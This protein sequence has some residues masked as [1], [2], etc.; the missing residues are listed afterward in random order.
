MLEIGYLPNALAFGL[1]ARGL[2]LI[3][4]ISFISIACQ[5]RGLVG[6]RG[7]T[8]LRATFRS[9]AH[10]FPSLSSRML[11]FFSL[12]WLC[13]TSDFALIAIPFF[14]ACCGLCAFCGVCTQLARVGCWVAMR[15]L[16]LPVGLLYPW[17]SLLL[18]LG[19]L[20]T[21]LPAAPPLWKA[22][23][24]GGM[25]GRAS[26]L[27]PVHPWLACAVRWLL[28]R[29]MLGFG[30]KKFVGTSLRH[31]CYIK[32]F[33]VAQP[34]PT[35][36]GWL[37]CR[38]PLPLFQFAL[39]VMFVVEC[40]APLFLLP[41]GGVRAFAALSIIMLML[42]IHIGG[43]FG[44]F[45]LLTVSMSLAC[46]DVTSS[47]FDPLPA[48]DKF[49]LTRRLALASYALLSVLFLPFDSW[50]TNAFSY[51]PQ[52]A[53]ARRPVIAALLRL[54]RFASD[55][56]L[57]HAYGV[58]PPHS[59]PPIRMVTLV[60]G[61][62]DGVLW[63]RYHWRHLPCSPTSRPSFVA[64]HHPR[65]DHSLF[66][67][68]FGTSPDN[69]L[70]P[71]NSARPYAFG[72]SSSTLHRLA[73]ALLSDGAPH[74]RR[75]FRVDPFPPGTPPP[76][77]VR[78]RLMSYEPTTL[79]HAMRTG[80]FWIEECI[81]VHLPPMTLQT[82]PT[83]SSMSRAP[84]SSHADG[85]TVIAKT[86]PARGARG[87]QATA[88][89]RRSG[90]SPARHEEPP[91]AAGE[92]ARAA[93]LPRGAFSDATIAQ[94]APL[95]PPAPGSRDPLL[96]HPDLMPIWRT[97]VPKLRR[98][99]AADLEGAGESEGEVSHHACANRPSPR[100]D[101]SSSGWSAA[102]RL[103]SL[104][105]LD[106]AFGSMADADALA[107]AFW[108]AFVPFV[109]AECSMSSWAD[110]DGGLPAR[111]ARVR[112]LFTPL[113]L[114]V[115]ELILGGLT[116]RIMP[117]LEHMHMRAALPRLGGAAP[118]YFHLVLL[119]HAIVLL[120]PL[121]VQAFL[122]APIPND[123]EDAS[124]ST[125]IPAATLAA[126]SAVQANNHMMWSNVVRIATSIELKQLL[127][128]GF[129]FYGVLWTD[130]MLAHARKHFV[131]HEMMRRYNDAPVPRHPC[132]IPGF[133]HLLPLIGEAL[134]PLV[135]EEQRFPLWKPPERLGDWERV[136]RA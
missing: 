49:E 28:V 136:R 71:I 1:F 64:P 24:S 125:V 89:R 111:H 77:F 10:D 30:K 60:E 128:K 99:L 93:R 45:N 50:C 110:A 107:L 6:A 55:Q 91:L 134:R 132:I 38:M 29:L 95:P 43:N 123:S 66:Y 114:H 131:A 105:A 84:F 130:T 37:A 90:R 120:G 113:Q 119:A 3:F 59:N 79:R 115:F 58:F 47:P 118:S 17:D 86:A 15:S 25:I 61:S 48:L 116:L 101:R 39:L 117:R 8:P 72:R 109:D 4:T 94:P 33:L 75:F 21:M 44:H 68:S 14:G 82:M 11:H 27:A 103:A 2:G 96:F 133:L 46:L 122:I 67:A 78:V 57:L 41:T 20:A 135:C 85:P 34:I 100:G 51:W 73:H 12:F 53:L 70:A 92:D 56:R 106:A 65:I 81:D 112:S 62:S 97:R 108:D 52:L 121:S 102:H 36:A 16:D 19:W 54:C 127:D 13:G 76:T 22:S 74:A 129:G 40:I 98:L 83:L 23:S 42:G 104:C 9:I 18:E 87:A 32:H 7:L 88:S 126:M 35:P 31:S 124:M 80:E 63:R 69:F 26:L 5:I